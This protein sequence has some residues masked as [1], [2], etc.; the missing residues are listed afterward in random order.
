M[1][2]LMSAFRGRCLARLGALVLF[3]GLAGTAWSMDAAERRSILDAARPVAARHAGQAV[4]IKVDVL[5]VD[6]GW[7][8]LVGNL[9]APSG[10]SLDWEK[11]GQCHPALDKMLWVVLKK[12]TGAWKVRHIE[13]C[14]SEPPYWYLDMLY[15][16]LVWP[17]GVYTGLD[18]GSEDGP[19]E[20]RCR[21]QR[22]RH[23]K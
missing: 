10:G 14:A 19:P 5:N 11:A 13:I 23:R 7:A 21:A 6:A 1:T 8:V 15:G 16:G 20:K 2:S 12:T 9:V 18:D 17:C 4:K 3:A 22:S